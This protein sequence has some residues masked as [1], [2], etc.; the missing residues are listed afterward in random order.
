[1]P[2]QN[3]LAALST[4]SAHHIV[5]GATHTD[6]AVEELAAAASSQAIRDIV[7][8]VRTGQSLEK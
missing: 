2:K 6:L 5:E 3:K 8:S 1:M 7:A 4:N